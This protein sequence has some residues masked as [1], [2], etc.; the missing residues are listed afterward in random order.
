[1]NSQRWQEAQPQVD[2]GKTCLPVQELEDC[3]AFLKKKKQWLPKYCLQTAQQWNRKSIK[4]VVK[5]RVLC[6]ALTSGALWNARPA[7][8]YPATK[9]DA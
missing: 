9:A 4:P 5:D 3:S 2:P 7:R 1:M 6:R 8:I